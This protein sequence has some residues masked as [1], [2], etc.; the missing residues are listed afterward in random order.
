MCQFLL[1]RWRPLTSLDSW[2]ATYVLLYCVS[3]GGQA[4]TSSVHCVCVCVGVCVCVCVWFA[5]NILKKEASLYSDSF[6]IQHGSNLFGLEA[7]PNY[8]AWYEINKLKYR[9]VYYTLH[10]QT[11]PRSKSRLYNLLIGEM[12]KKQK[13]T[14]C[15]FSSLGSLLLKVIDTVL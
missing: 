8:N 10:Q 14:V 1:R 3:S 5:F 6:F 2:L 4:G 15:S 12:E 7:V 9:L 11:M 13:K